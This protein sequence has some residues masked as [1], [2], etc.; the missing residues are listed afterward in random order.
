MN[1]DQQKK[2]NIAII[3]A[4]LI[5]EKMGELLDILEDI[6]K[7]CPACKKLEKSYADSSSQIGN[8]SETT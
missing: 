1:E 8:S 2:L 4:L 7:E 6:E 3:G 5:G